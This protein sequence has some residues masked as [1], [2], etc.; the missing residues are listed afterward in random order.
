M[1]ESSPI[2]VLAK[3]LAFKWYTCIVVHV[4]C[5]WVVHHL[6]IILAMSSLLLL[7]RLMTFMC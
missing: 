1:V 4:Y 2:K 3:F 5:V 6:E 7:W